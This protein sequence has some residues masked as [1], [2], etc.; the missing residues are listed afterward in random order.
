MGSFADEEAA[1]SAA[2]KGDADAFGA[3]Y[4]QNLDR[5]FR[6]ALRLARNRH[7]AEDLVAAAFMELWRRRSRVRVVDGSV[8]PWLLVTVNNLDR[9]RTRALRRYR[10]LLASLPRGELASPGADRVVEEVP[11]QGAV[12][13][14]RDA[15]RHVAPPDAAL[16]SLVAFEDY[17]P[18]QAAEVLGIS[19]GAAR[20]RLHR[21][22]RRIAAVLGKD[23]SPSDLTPFT[24]EDLG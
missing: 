11:T 4:D 14:V 9:N 23:P 6:H 16:V 22:R 18:A 19:A 24:L 8:L 13:S 21:A 15:L 2:R 3:V 7:D 12:A 10:S 17:T 1:W 5:T 20:T